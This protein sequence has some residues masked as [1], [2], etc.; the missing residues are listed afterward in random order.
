MTST[1]L[2]MEQMK[3]PWMSSKSHQNLSIKQNSQCLSYRPSLT[4]PLR[5]RLSFRKCLKLYS[6][7]LLQLVQPRH[8]HLQAQ[9][10]SRERSFAATWHIAFH[11]FGW[12]TENQQEHKCSGR[13][14]LGQVL[15]CHLTVSRTIYTALPSRCL[16][17][18][19]E[20]IRLM[21]MTTR[22]FNCL[23]LF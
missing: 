10:E 12:E 9:V 8:M 6:M 16:C 14:N 3:S 5:L 4:S 22:G 2:D 15:G 7:R 17:W 18:C 13:L 11:F 23:L 19:I 21:H 1:E 20:V